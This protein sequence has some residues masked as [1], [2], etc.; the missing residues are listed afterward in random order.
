MKPH[1]TLVNPPTPMGAVGHLPFALLGLGYLAAVLE[2]NHYQVDVID[3]Q[4]LKLSFD[5][6]RSELR[7]RKPDVVGMTATTL[8]YK[9]ALQIA[10]IAKEVHPNCVTALGG[11]HVTFWD[12][13]ALEECPQLDVVVRREGE[14]TML[15]LV[16]R[17]EKGKDYND[18]V[19]T[20][21]RKNGKII[22]NPD[23]LYIE[24]LDSLPFPA[25]HLWPM[26]KLR[27]TEDILY[28]ATSR[29]CVYWCEF[30]TTVRMH[31]RKYRIR[32]PKNV[33]NELEF[34]HKTY[35]V[36]NFTFCDDAFTVDQART[37]DLC[38]DILS[39]G[40]KIKWN[41][42]TR[43]DMLTKDLLQKMK[44][45]GCISVWFGVESGSQQVLDAMKKGITPELTA[46]VFGWVR[47]VGL[48][49][50]PNVILGFPGETKKSAWETIKFIEKISPDDVGFYNVATPFPG[51][52]MYDLVLEKGWLR[53]TNFDRYDT[54]TPI[55]ETPWLS[56]KE[57]GKL[58]EGAFHH[59]Y[60]RR[61]YF[62]DKRR[63]FKLS[64]ALAVAMHLIANIKLK[65]RTK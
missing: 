60:L 37:K 40:L 53:V 9:S 62:F 15:E 3:C 43:V 32:S 18:V 47:E 6:S 50:V 11:P 13:K 16:Q 25:R 42:G 58:R 1:V 24:D 33:V 31:G 27:E 23:R 7:K 49:P 29:G 4:V 22:R 30:C 44:E 65:L 5:E 56:M 36:S 39:R 26:E 12:D 10:R 64:T 59:F 8:T 48:K 41:C 2:K 57:L 20:T 45:A 54:T 35:N 46:K 63:R 17:I 21:C 51:T 28:L 19:G 34:L 55:F 14:N 61:A 38:N 52:P